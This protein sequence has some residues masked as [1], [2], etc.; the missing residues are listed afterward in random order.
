M[1][2]PTYE[3]EADAW[4]CVADVLESGEMPP[5][6]CSARKE[7][8]IGLC[9]IVSRL[10]VEGHITHYTWLA[11]RERI[12]RTLRHRGATNFGP[13]YQVAGR[14]EAARAFELAARKEGV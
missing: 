14:L 3:T 1:T 8:C 4:Q 2:T 11:M 6:E 10:R 12:N 9:T 13:W 7:R 5:Y